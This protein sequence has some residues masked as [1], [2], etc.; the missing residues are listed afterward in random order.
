MYNRRLSTA[1]LR[2][3]FPARGT[4][5][6]IALQQG[7]QLHIKDDNGRVLAIIQLGLDT[8]VG[9]AVKKHELVDENK[10]VQGEIRPVRVIEI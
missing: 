6:L 9:V 2:V 1:S 8:P 7:D 4:T 10:P 5:K 3:T